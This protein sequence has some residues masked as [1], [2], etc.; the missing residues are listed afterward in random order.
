MWSSLN[1]VSNIPTLYS[2]WRPFKKNEFI[3]LFL[4]YY[5][6]KWSYILT[7]AELQWVVDHIIQVFL[8]FVFFSVNRFITIMYI[9]ENKDHIKIFCPEIWAEMIFV[10]LTFK[11]LF[12]TITF[13]PPSKMAGITVSRKFIKQNLEVK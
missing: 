7:S 9:L 3:C 6:S 10:W 4:P 5:Q 13:Y 2:T 11:I 8:W 12:D 1:I